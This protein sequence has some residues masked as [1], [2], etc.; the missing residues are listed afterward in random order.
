MTLFRKLSGAS[1]EK[2]QRHSCAV[3]VESS[4]RIMT[5]SSLKLDGTPPRVKVRARHV[6]SGQLAASQRH[7][8]GKKIDQNPRAKNR[9]KFR[10]AAIRRKGQV[11]SDVT[12]GSGAYEGELTGIKKN[13]S[14]STRF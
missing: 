4:E 5:D 8:G 13:V 6:E 7:L 10:K 3:A 9:E 14:H 1:R 11:R 2:I 12:P